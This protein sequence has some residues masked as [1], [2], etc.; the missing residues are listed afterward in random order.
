MP[1]A[2]RF[3]VPNRLPST[4]MEKPS[5][6]SNSSAGPPARSTRSQISVISR[7]GDTGTRMRFSSPRDSSCAR[8]SRRSR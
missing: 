1:M 8:K 3:G 2:T 6:F 5:G 7:R 4:G